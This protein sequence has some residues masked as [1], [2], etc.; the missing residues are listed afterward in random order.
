MIFAKAEILN[1]LLACSAFAGAENP[2]TSND[3][4]I[5][6]K[7]CDENQISQNKN[8]T[9]I[10]LEMKA[11][12]EDEVCRVKEE[13]SLYVLDILDL[14]KETCEMHHDELYDLMAEIATHK[15]A[16]H[17]AVSILDAEKLNKIRN[18]ERS[19]EYDRILA[20]LKR[21]EDVFNSINDLK[22]KAFSEILDW[23]DKYSFSKVCPILV[24]YFK[25]DI[26]TKFRAFKEIC[27]KSRE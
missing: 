16:V 23:S 24:S 4:H 10:K 6:A 25:N 9:I 27:D 1:A 20:V 26:S 8:Y 11:K 14:Y 19:Y 12:N 18:N 21:G 13:L 5:L 17:K 7:N 3:S 22:S 15:A 2:D